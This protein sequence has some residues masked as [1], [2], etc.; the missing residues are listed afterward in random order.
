MSGYNYMQTEVKLTVDLVQIKR[1]MVFISVSLIQVKSYCFSFV[2]PQ[3]WLHPTMEQGK[4]MH[5]YIKL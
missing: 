4:G 2:D 3:P 5:E 1:F